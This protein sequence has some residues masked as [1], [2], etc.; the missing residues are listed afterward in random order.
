[1]TEAANWKYGTRACGSCH[2]G[3]LAV[4]HIKANTNEGFAT[5][6]LCHAPGRVAPV[7]EA[8]YGVQE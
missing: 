3:D 5:C 7:E 2:D 6:T 4:A 1:M 8:H